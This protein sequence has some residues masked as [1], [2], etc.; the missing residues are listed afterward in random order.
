MANRG[1]PLDEKRREELMARLP[2]PIDE[3]STDDWTDYL[4]LNR[5]GYTYIKDVRAED[6]EMTYFIEVDPNGGR[7]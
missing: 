4:A 5:A 6:G 7:Y 1:M 2:L 3:P